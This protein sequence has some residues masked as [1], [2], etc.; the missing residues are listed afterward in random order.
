MNFLLI[1]G[2]VFIQLVER[3]KSSFYLDNNLQSKLQTFLTSQGYEY[4][5]NSVTNIIP[6]TPERT[7]GLVTCTNTTS[8]FNLVGFKTT[9]YE[10]EPTAYYSRD[11]AYIQSET[12]NY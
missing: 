4:S 10:A 2:L 3:I 12:Y 8:Q 11:L 7:L 5:E 1:L 9:A 6:N